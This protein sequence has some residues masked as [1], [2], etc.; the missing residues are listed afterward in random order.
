MRLRYEE[1]EHTADLALRIY[2]RDERELLLNAAHALKEQ[3]CGPQEVE[4]RLQ[5]RVELKAP[6]PEELLVD[7]LNELIYLH[8]V[9]GEVYGQCEIALPAPGWL[10]A[11]LGGDRVGR[12]RKWVKAATFHELE[13]RKGEDGLEALVV[14]DV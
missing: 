11:K 1:V 5:R 3:L 4:L 14:F 10:V 8:E 6:S 9:A 7:W 2:G 13:I 12:V